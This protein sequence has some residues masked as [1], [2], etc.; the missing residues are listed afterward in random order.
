MD[1]KTA[2]IAK[3][4]CVDVS[5]LAGAVGCIEHLSTRGG[6][7][8]AKVSMGNPLT[9]EDSGLYPLTHLELC[10]ESAKKVVARYFV[11]STTKTQTREPTMIVRILASFTRE[12]ALIGERAQITAGPNCHGEVEA[13]LMGSSDYIRKNTDGYVILLNGEYETL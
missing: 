2:R 12:P 13:R 4:T 7:K 6:V 10:G 9:F 5:T 8:G 3:E 11:L 1:A